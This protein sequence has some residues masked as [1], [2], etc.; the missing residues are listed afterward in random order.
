MSKPSQSVPQIDPEAR[1]RPA[2]PAAGGADPK[3]ARLKAALKANL[4][5]RKAQ[6]RQR[7]GGEAGQAVEPGDE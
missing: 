5:R 3:A 1:P 4:A 2:R 6:L 7:A